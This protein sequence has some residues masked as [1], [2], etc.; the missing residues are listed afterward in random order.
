MPS[1]GSLSLRHVEILIPQL[2][3]CK[4]VPFDRPF[5]FPCV[6]TQTRRDLSLS[7]SPL[8]KKAKIALCSQEWLIARG[9]SRSRE[10]NGANRSKFVKMLIKEAHER[11]FAN[12]GGE[13]VRKA[14]YIRWEIYP[15]W[16]RRETRILCVWDFS[17][18]VVSII[19]RDRAQVMRKSGAPKSERFVTYRGNVNGMREMT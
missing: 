6:T 16:R 7:L 8:C 3:L 14:W 15:L 12:S 13:R 10:K 17:G 1:I 4:Y 2:S 19:S 9:G 18:A 11:L 5:T